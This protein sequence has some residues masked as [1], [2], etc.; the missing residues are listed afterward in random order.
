MADHNPPFLQSVDA[1]APARPDGAGALPS[2]GPNR[3][4]SVLLGRRGWSADH[5]TPPLLPS[6]QIN[7]YDPWH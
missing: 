4:R 5:P 6:R 2:H 3:I 1:R 7:L